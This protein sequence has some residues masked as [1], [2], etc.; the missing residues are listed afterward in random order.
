M[1]PPAFEILLYLFFTKYHVLMSA[2]FLCVVFAWQKNWGQFVTE[3]NESTNEVSDVAALLL[4]WV[5][6]AGDG[7]SLVLQVSGSFV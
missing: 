6:H 7:E 5:A 4:G 1:V 2:S 3:T